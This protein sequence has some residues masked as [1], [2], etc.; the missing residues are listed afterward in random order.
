MQRELQIVI[1]VDGGAGD[2]YDHCTPDQIRD[3][4]DALESEL[5]ELQNETGWKPWATSRHV[6]IEAAQGEWIDAWHFMMSLAMQLQL[7]PDRIFELYVE[8]RNRNL[9][10][11]ENHDYTGLDKCPGCKRAWDD[12]QAH[13]LDF[14]LKQVTTQQGITYCSTNCLYGIE[15]V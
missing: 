8:K 12:I 14:A 11:H 3:T 2:P 4:K 6:N 7:T 10:R 1:G 15:K 5:D 13:D 9:Q